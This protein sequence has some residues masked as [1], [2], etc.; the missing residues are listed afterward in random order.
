MLPL[1]TAMFVSQL[2]RQLVTIFKKSTQPQCKLKLVVRCSTNRC[3]CVHT[4]LYR[5]ALIFFMILQLFNIAT[6][7]QFAFHIMFEW[8]QWHRYWQVNWF[9][10][11]MIPA[12][13]TLHESPQFNN[14]SKK[15]S[16]F[17]YNECMCDHDHRQNKRGNLSQNFENAEL[18]S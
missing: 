2:V 6:L 3:T 15:T 4:A 12:L 11:N 14:K 7:V 17:K 16:N 10:S 9:L 8:N 13:L 5:G 18:F 1:Y